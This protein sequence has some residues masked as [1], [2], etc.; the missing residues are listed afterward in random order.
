MTAAGAAWAVFAFVS[1]FQYG[2]LQFCVVVQN[3]SLLNYLI[4]QQNCFA[5]VFAICAY[6]L[7]YLLSFYIDVH[8]I[9]LVSIIYMLCHF[10]INKKNHY[11]NF[12]QVY[13]LTFHL[14]LKRQM[15]TRPNYF[16]MYIPTQEK[17]LPVTFGE[18]QAL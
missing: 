3:S 16:V 9:D 14:V 8:N 11:K 15:I 2:G 4:I 12:C 7:H 1:F 13:L 10:Y 17:I 18:M 5:Q 6:I